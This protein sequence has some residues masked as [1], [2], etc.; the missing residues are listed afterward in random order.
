[1]NPYK[2]T[3]EPIPGFKPSSKPIGH[4]PLSPLK[5]IDHTDDELFLAL[6]LVK[7]NGG[8]N[9][10][11]INQVSKDFN[12]D[13]LPLKFKNVIKFANL[14][15]HVIIQAQKILKDTGSVQLNHRIGCED[16]FELQIISGYNST[17]DNTGF[18]CKWICLPNADDPKDQVT[19]TNSLNKD[20]FISDKKDIRKFY[21]YQIAT[22]ILKYLHE[23]DQLSKLNDIKKSSFYVTLYDHVNNIDKKEYIDI[24]IPTFN[25]DGMKSEI[26][27][28]NSGEVTRI[29]NNIHPIVFGSKIG[30]RRRIG[31][32]KDRKAQV[33]VSASMARAQVARYN[34]RKQAEK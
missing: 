11:N 23:N 15:I 27:Q 13:S 4:K 26:E 29:Y 12:F 10:R 33:T 6:G 7:A 30:K 17:G 16:M 20:I 1:M 24:D 31:N 34:D 8:E 19:T 21:S 3:L 28:I 25:I 32:G 22:W 5:N 18:T 14:F 9:M 2:R